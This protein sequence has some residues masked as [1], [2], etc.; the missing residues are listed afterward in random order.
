VES[1]GSSSE[2]SYPEMTSIW[3]DNKIPPIKENHKQSKQCRAKSASHVMC[4]SG[5]Q[6]VTVA[7]D[8][9]C[10]QGG[11]KAVGQGMQKPTLSARSSSEP[12]NLDEIAEDNDFTVMNTKKRQSKT[13]IKPTISATQLIE[14]F[15]PLPLLRVMFL[16]AQ[17]TNY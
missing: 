8:V 13:K 9:H 14:F 3:A 2:N 17:S 4:P 1:D 10:S 12:P 15:H 11:T 6:S 5:S 16:V 7:A